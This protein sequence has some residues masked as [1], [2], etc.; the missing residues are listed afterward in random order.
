MTRRLDPLD[1]VK[2]LG[3]A[4]VPFAFDV[5]AMIWADDAPKLEKELHRFFVLN[6]MNK[7]NPRKEFFRLS[8]AQLKDHVTSLGID[9]SWTINAAAAEY[10]ETLAI[11][12]KIAKDNS[13]KEEWLRHQYIEAA[14]QERHDRDLE[15]SAAA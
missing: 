14:V 7:A 4:S 3:D 5:H 1:R 6:Q 10:R 8:L 13:A 12:E 11:E 9:A 15:L 2:E